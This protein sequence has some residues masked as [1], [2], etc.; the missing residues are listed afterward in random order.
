MNGRKCN[1]QHGGIVPPSQLVKSLCLHNFDQQMSSACYV[2]SMVWTL[3]HVYT[4]IVIVLG[5]S[6]PLSCAA[7]SCWTQIFS[8]LDYQMYI[9]LSEII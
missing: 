7:S 1:V 4:I 5:V 8:K 3:F 6:G 9:L 2:S